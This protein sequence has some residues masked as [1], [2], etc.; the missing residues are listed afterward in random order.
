MGRSVSTSAFLPLPSEDCAEISS[1]GDDAGTFGIA[2]GVALGVGA[3]VGL[4][5]LAYALWP[6]STQSGA[7]THIVPLVSPDVA[8]A[9]FRGSF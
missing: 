2:G 7:A 4:A 3:A 6:E 9:V 1:L 8:G 5:T